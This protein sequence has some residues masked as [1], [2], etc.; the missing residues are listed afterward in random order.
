M[1]PERSDRPAASP[2]SRRRQGVRRGAKRRSTLAYVLALLVLLPGTI[3]LEYWLDRKDS[4]E[5]MH[6]AVVVAKGATGSYAGGTW[7]FIVM[8]PG[9]ERKDA[10]IPKDTAVVYVGLSVTPSDARASKRIY[11]CQFK[12]VDDRGRQWNA[13]RSSVADF[14]AVG[15]PA[16]GCYQKAGEYEQKPIAPGQN[17]KIV[18][19]FLVPK[20]AVKS[21]RLQVQVRGAAP[22]YLEFNR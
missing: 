9:P 17:Q 10:R 20:D 11:D 5:L 2:T 6:E 4:P 19:A 8:V 1:P 13:A 12:A 16:T 15:D 18:T 3:G 21:L 7:K 22:R 14:E